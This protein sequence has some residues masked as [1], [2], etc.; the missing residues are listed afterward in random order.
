M[1]LFQYRTKGPLTLTVNLMMQE[2]LICRSQQAIQFP[3]ILFKLLRCRWGDAYKLC[4]GDIFHLMHWLS[5]GSE[6]ANH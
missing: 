5:Y 2:I 4:F 6:V 3:E 1:S